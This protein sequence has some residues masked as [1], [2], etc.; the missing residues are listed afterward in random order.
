MNYQLE[1][2]DKNA[3]LASDAYMN[4]QHPVIQQKAA[5]L[6][7][8]DMSEVEKIKAAFTFVRDGI[9]HTGDIG[10]HDIA[11]NAVEA[12]EQ[13]HAV[14]YVKSMLLAA[15]LRSQGI[16]TGLCYQR[17]ARANDHIIHA[18]NAVYLT[19]LQKWARVD[20]RGN[21]PGK[22]AEFYTDAPDKEQLVFNVRAEMDEIDYLTI[23]AQPPAVTT[24]VLEENTDCAEVLKCKLPARL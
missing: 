14:C 15:L 20:A 17:L 23:Y 4:W 8:D 22:E 6:F 9:P 19:D 5:E 12:L 10:G 1:T 11:H 21:L 16:A 18:L 3:Y 13:G 7:R 24:K 2:E